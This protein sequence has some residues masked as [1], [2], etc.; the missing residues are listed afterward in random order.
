MK[1]AIKTVAKHIDSQFD[2]SNL[3]TFGENS[4]A[5]SYGEEL[6]TEFTNYFSEEW[7]GTHW[8]TIEFIC[9]PDMVSRAFANAVLS[10]YAASRPFTY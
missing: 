3:I 5:D 10:Q 9:I 7:H 1:P 2:Y 4:L 6:C 8:E